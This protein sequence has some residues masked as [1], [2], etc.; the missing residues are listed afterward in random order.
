M[1]SHQSQWDFKR[2]QGDFMMEYHHMKNLS[3]WTPIWLKIGIFKVILR[4]LTTFTCEFVWNVK[5]RHL[6]SLNDKITVHFDVLITKY[7]YFQA[8][9]QNV[10]NPAR[11]SKTGRDSVIS[12]H[13][14][15]LQVTRETLCLTSI[16]WSKMHH[17]KLKTGRNVTK[18]HI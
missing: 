12:E 13:L 18:W 3:V 16:K 8:N 17:F 7:W 9:R 11:Y 10:V 5:I 15:L 2:S 14:G 4:C 1:W 6:W